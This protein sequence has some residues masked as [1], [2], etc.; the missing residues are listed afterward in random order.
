M[1]DVLCQAFCK[2][3]LLVHEPG[4]EQR[5]ART[6]VE[7]MPL[8]YFPELNTLGV[9]EVKKL[10]VGDDMDGLEDLSSGAVYQLRCPLLPCLQIIRRHKL[11]ILF[12]NN[13]EP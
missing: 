13:P 5:D 9:L 7:S 6:T 4:A 2:E 11:G 12:L 3:L 10:T 1:D 8:N